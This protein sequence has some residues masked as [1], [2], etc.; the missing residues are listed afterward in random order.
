VTYATLRADI[1][2]RLDRV[3]IKHAGWWLL[4]RVHLDAAH[5]RAVAIYLHDAGF[6]EPTPVSDADYR[7]LGHAVGSASTAP[8]MQ[9]RRHHLLAMFTPLRLIDRP[10]G[11]W[12]RLKLTA[13][14]HRLATEADSSGVLEEALQGIVFCREPWYTPTRVEVFEHFDVSAYQAILDVMRGCDGWI[15]RDEYDLVVSRLWDATE[16]EWAMAAISEIR[17]LN[18]SQ[19]TELLAEVGNRWPADNPKPYA[20]WRDTGLQ[21]F[22]LFSLG[23][24]A[25]RIDRRLVLCDVPLALQGASS[26]AADDTTQPTLPPAETTPS[27]GGAEP[28]ESTV[29]PRTLALPPMVV[30]PES[31]LATPPV[32]PDAN[33]GVEG[34]LLV[35]KLLQGDGWQVVYYGSRRGFGFDIWAKR[36]D[37]VILVEVKSSLGAASTIRLTRL[38]HKAAQH[39]GANFVLAVVEDLSTTH[40]RIHLIIGPA[41]KV[42]FGEAT[43]TE[44][45][46]GRAEWAC[47]AVESLGT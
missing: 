21:V 5:L 3:E 31:E 20:N 1:I 36:G 43:T 39:H 35:G 17:S 40:P 19:R 45:L 27:I 15:D 44:Y 34:E 42:S 22:S 12:S 29:A 37:E 11:G 13:L 18:E 24:S 25:I 2:E 16:V 10:A 30:D 14:G 38:E 9:L 7:A 28:P 46:V 32:A 4:T 6:D 23:T 26:S 33:T 8:G 47:H 41:G